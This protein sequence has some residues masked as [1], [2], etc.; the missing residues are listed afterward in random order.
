LITDT[1][2]T[3]TVNA[4]AIVDRDR[5]FDI[6]G[7]AAKDTLTGGGGNDT[8]SG[9]GGA[10]NITGG[11]GADNL[12]G[13]SGKDN[14]IYAL[15]DNQTAI[16]GESRQSGPDTI[17]DF[18]TASDIVRVAYTV[19]ADA[20]VDFTNKGA[21]A[22]NANGMSLLSSVL[23]QYFYNTGTKSIVMDTDANGLL[24]AGDF[25]V[26]VG[27]EALGTKDVQAY[28]TTAG[29]AETVTTGSGNDQ[30]TLLD[31]TSAKID[32][33]TTGAGND[34]ILTSQ[35][36]LNVGG[37]G[38]DI[39]NM[40]A[41]TDTLSISGTGTTVSPAND[42]ALVGVENITFTS[43]GHTLDLSAQTEALNITTFS[44]TNVI[45][46]GGAA[47]ASGFTGSS[48]ATGA[49][50]LV[51]NQAQ[52]AVMTTV[53]GG[54]GTDIL[55]LAATTALV[56]ADFGR[57][58]NMENL[59]L[60]GISTITLGTAA[61]AALGAS[62]IVTTGNSTT[63]ITSTM[64]LTNIA[65][66]A[67]ATT[68][69][70]TLAGSSN[71]VVTNSGTSFD[72]VTTD[73]TS[74]GTVTVGLGNVNANTAT[75]VV[76]GSGATAVTSAAGDT[77]T[78]T[79]LDAASGAFTLNTGI[80]AIT[81]GAGAQTIGGT[82]TGGTIN[83][84]IGQDT[85]TAGVAGDYIIVLA[86]DGATAGHAHTTFVN[87]GGVWAT[88]GSDKIH[89]AQATAGSVGGIG[90]NDTTVANG[91][92][93]TGVTG[94]LVPVNAELYVATTNMATS[95]AANAVANFAAISSLAFAGNV[96]AT[97]TKIL[98]GDDSADTFIFKFTSAANDTS[99][100]AGELE[101]IGIVDGLAATVHGDF[102]FIA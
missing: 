69:V 35:G 10:D 99:I 52:L 28:I 58:T 92:T 30:V 9:G 34:V 64:T 56:D 39:I 98:V 74:T 6:T 87:T 61:D 66:D 15:A 3:V 42:A 59:Q 55:Q 48:N 50:T 85:I 75:V 51:T 18:G 16:T 96:A 101:L 12:T 57:V 63:G 84:G 68:K 54:L 46:I 77:I 41:G 32:T 70:L 14:F 88:G 37:S 93:N 67:L 23:G 5:L 90:N 95:T 20:T 83:A 13:G 25:A 60:T 100:L 19:A 73:A 31:T 71:Y 1:T 24:Q 4:A 89:I 94:S 22:D 11:P 21:A 86:D 26:N 7:G 40:G 45:T 82:M 80:A 81:A 2:D 17:T 91:A 49:D 33:I 29:G 97:T 8:I 43:A 44:G 53:D 36:G 76:N 27:L 65:A 78:V 38:G 79:G 47:V 72:R 62:D 102:A